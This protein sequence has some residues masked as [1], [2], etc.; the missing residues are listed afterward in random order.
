MNVKLPVAVGV[1]VYAPVAASSAM[2]GGSAP[3]LTLQVM[4]VEPLAVKLVAADAV[5][6]MLAPSGDA[7][8]VMSGVCS[9]VCVYAWLAMPARLVAVM[10]KLNTPMAVGVP[11]YW[12]LAFNAHGRA[13]R[14][15]RSRRR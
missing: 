13:A 9:M 11:V 15:R 2:P 12:P 3:P 7:G 5:P 8:A 14:R 1:P 4:G 6:A 10:V